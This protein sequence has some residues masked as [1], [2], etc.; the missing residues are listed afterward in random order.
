MEPTGKPGAGALPLTPAGSLALAA[1]R[2]AARRRLRPWCLVAPMLLVMLI[3]TVFPLAYSLLVSFTR[4]ELARGTGWEFVGWANYREALGDQRFLASAAQTTQIIL[5]ALAAAFVL[6]FGLALLLNR[7]FPG[8][9]LFVSLLAVPVMVAPTAA[10]MS[11][12]LMLTPKYGA[13]NDFLSTLAGQRVLIDWLGSPGLARLSIA[14]V[15]VWRWAP[16]YMLVLLAGLQAIPDELYEAGRVDG[17]TRLQLFGFITL[18][19]LRWPALVGL[20]IGFIDL[21]KLFDTVYIMTT[22]GPGGSTE[23]VTFYTYY[24][25]VRFFHVGYGAALS[26]YVLA[27]VLLLS[28]L[29]VR[30]SARR[31]EAVV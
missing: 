31:E 17:A 23:T 9:G 18:P 10:A 28:I 29:L 3:T 2:R 27:T 7:S 1:G 12:A 14:V 21:V 16:F 8:R 6:G 25:G 30:V 19:L 22:G 11:F 4:Y 24:T 20:L 13:A 5:P 26:F 15:Q